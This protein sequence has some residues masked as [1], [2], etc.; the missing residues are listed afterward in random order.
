MAQGFQRR[1][2]VADRRIVRA[3]LQDWFSHRPSPLKPMR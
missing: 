3:F 1:L 2:Q